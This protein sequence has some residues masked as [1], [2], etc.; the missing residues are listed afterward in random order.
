MK[1]TYSVLLNAAT[2]F[3]L[4]TYNFFFSL[5]SPSFLCT[6]GPSFLPLSN[7]NSE[8]KKK[9]HTNQHECVFFCA[10]THGNAQTHKM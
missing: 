3:T 7:V 5:I 4:T 1:A 9:K 8:K 6:S 10:C 2:L